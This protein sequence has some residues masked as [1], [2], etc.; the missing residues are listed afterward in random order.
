MASRFMYGSDEEV[1][2]ASVDDLIAS[3]VK[4]IGAES[5]DARTAIRQAIGDAAHAMSDEDID[6]IIAAASASAQAT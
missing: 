5:N 6:R 2:P 3:G 1:T 4:P